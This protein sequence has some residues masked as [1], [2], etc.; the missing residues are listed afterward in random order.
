[1]LRIAIMISIMAVLLPG[2][3]QSQNK[4]EVKSKHGDWEL[5]C[6]ESCFLLQAVKSGTVVLT[7]VVV[8]NTE[9]QPVLRMIA[10]LGVLLASDNQD[11][12][13]SIDGTDFGSSGF[14]KCLSQTGCVTER[15]ATTPVLEKLKAGNVATFSIRTTPQKKIAIPISLKGFTAGYNALP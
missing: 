4:S 3:A 11:M 8:K 9:G 6:A 15:A 14:V 1:M 10:P 7:V 13:M 2:D 12:E 5:R